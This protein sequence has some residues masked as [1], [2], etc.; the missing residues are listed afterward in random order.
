MARKYKAMIYEELPPE[1]DGSIRLRRVTSAQYITVPQ[2][3]ATLRVSVQ[4]VYRLV[5]QGVIKA[6]RVGSLVR[7]GVA[8]FVDYLERARNIEYE[9]PDR[10]E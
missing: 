4:T 8:D 10:H 7:I 5:E 2:A 1:P 6:S 9:R 3:A